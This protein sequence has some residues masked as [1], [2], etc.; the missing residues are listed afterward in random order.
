MAFCE[1]LSEQLGIVATVDPQT[2]ASAAITSDVVA[3][4][5][6]RRAMFILQ[7]GAGNTGGILV[8]IQE[9]NAG[10]TALTATILTRAATAC[11]GLNSQYL[12]EVSAEAMGAGCTAL[13]AVITPTATPLLSLICLADVERYHPASDRDLASVVAIQAAN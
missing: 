9:A 6:H 2:G 3:M 8:N 7:T 11:V 5:M 12:F 10:F 4:G 13:R 1:R